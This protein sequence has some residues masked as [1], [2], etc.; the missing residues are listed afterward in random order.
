MLNNKTNLKKN[1]N[2]NS[3]NN[4]FLKK[5]ITKNCSASKE[6]RIIIGLRFFKQ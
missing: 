4:T 2:I 5:V 1:V 3:E 6:I